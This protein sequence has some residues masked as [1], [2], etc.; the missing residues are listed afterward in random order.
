MPAMHTA[1]PHAPACR[2][3]YVQGDARVTAP[4]MPRRLLLP[5]GF[6]TADGLG[7]S[8][9]N[10]RSGVTL[11][12]TAHATVQS[13]REAPPP[14][15]CRMLGVLCC[16]TRCLCYV[17]SRAGACRACCAAPACTAPAANAA[18][19][20]KRAPPSS[21]T[22]ARTSSAPRCA[23]L[24]CVS[25]ACCVQSTATTA[26]LRQVEGV[27]PLADRVQQALAQHLLAGVGRQLQVVL[28]G[29]DCRGCD[30]GGGR[31]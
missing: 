7:G 10:E 13:R 1:R 23:A 29:H 14:L 6:Q 30:K 11:Q 17:C 24:C 25:C 3:Q 28:A 31:G 22:T 12:A 4:C 15:A 5:L 2:L 9:Q 16:T 26:V 20:A 19:C 8:S 18:C 27:L 21:A